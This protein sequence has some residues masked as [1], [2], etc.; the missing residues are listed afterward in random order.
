VR[1]GNQQ[2][3]ERF[4]ENLRTWCGL[5]NGKTVNRMLCAGKVER[6]GEGEKVS[7]WGGGEEVG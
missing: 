7:G 3:E 2:E 5:K 6:G 1:V 4:V